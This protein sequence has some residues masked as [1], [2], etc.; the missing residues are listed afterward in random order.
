M[1][2]LN[3]YLLELYDLNDIQHR[4]NLYRDMI[5]AIH[6]F[7]RLRQTLAAEGGGYS[8]PTLKVEGQSTPKHHEL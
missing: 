8:P 3:Y 6:K 2:R 1:Y 4:T 7:L 5:Y